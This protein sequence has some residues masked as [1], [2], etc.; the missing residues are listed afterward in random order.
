MV[1]TIFTLQEK[2]TSVLAKK[3]YGNQVSNNKPKEHCL[4]CTRSYG[5]RTTSKVKGSSFYA[6]KN[7]DSNK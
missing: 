1:K 4:L 2:E 5:M 6:K 7:T 3:T